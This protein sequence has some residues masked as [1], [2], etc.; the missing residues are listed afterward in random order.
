M[1]KIRE[2]QEVSKG[3]CE[4]EK[5]RADYMKKQFA[6]HKKIWETVSFIF[7]YLF[8]SI[9]V[10]KFQEKLLLLFDKDTGYTWEQV[11]ALTIIFLLLK[12]FKVFFILGKIRNIRPGGYCKTTSP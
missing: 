5:E 1:R 11:R 6:E 10:L 9:K 2:L 12:S 3:E 4:L 8:V 7:L